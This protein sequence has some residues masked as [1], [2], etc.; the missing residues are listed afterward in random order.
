MSLAL[1]DEFFPA[2]ERKSDL[3]LILDS[4]GTV[5]D[6][7]DWKHRDCFAPLF[8]RDFV[9]ESLRHAAMEAW[10]F[11]C[12][13][14][15][16][17]G[18]NRYPALLTSLRLLASHPDAADF[19]PGDLSELEAWLEVADRH[20]LPS[21]KAEA[22]RRGSSFLS[23]VA[24]WSEAVNARI[25]STGPSK[26]FPAAAAVI[27]ALPANRGLF[28]LMVVSQS[29]IEDIRR[30]WAA[31]HLSDL[32]LCM[33]GQEAGSKADSIRRAMASGYRDALVVGDTFQD[34]QAAS[35]AGAAFYPVIPG[36]E[37]ESWSSFLEKALPAFLSS[38]YR[39]SWQEAHL[40][41]LNAALPSEAPWSHKKA[42][43]LAAAV[44]W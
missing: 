28:D 37:A 31:N 36:Q 41:A 6:S 35:D 20:S 4:D 34:A 23:R 25:R 27:S 38:S 5:L 2:F 11:V 9:P 14:S 22:A 39:S 12:L 10:A 42:E 7:M 17:R 29:V 1:S 30:E 24:S 19:D 26:A 21:L 15:R 33:V 3:L 43:P 13:D 8:A 16:T 44:N 18:M 32:P 40:K